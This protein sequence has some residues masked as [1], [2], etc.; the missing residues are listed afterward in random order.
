MP[1]HAQALINKDCSADFTEC[2]R[3]MG[4]VL[5]LSHVD[6]L[7]LLINHVTTGA[8]EWAT[9]SPPAARRRHRV[10]TSLD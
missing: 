10:E 7:A 2:C 5:F 3:N 6:L 8:R 4:R 9:G 1:V